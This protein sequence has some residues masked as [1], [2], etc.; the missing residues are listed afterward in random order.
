MYLIAYT[1]KAA[2]VRKEGWNEVPVFF[3]GQDGQLIPQNYLLDFMHPRP[4]M[5]RTV[6]LLDGFRHSSR[7]SV[8][9]SD[10]RYFSRIGL[11]SYMSSW[12]LPQPTGGTAIG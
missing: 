3:N 12:P 1:T 10:A 11:T 5:S 8:K 7:T 6:Q 2:G 9:R 4:A